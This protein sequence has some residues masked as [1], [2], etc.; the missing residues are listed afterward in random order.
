[1]NSS[2]VFGI[3]FPVWFYSAGEMIRKVWIEYLKNH[4]NH[5]DKP[6]TLGTQF[7]WHVFGMLHYHVLSLFRTIRWHGCFRLLTCNFV[8]NHGVC[9]R[10]TCHAYSIRTWLGFIIHAPMHIND[11]KG[12]L[13]TPVKGICQV[14]DMLSLKVKTIPIPIV[15]QICLSQ[16]MTSQWRH[17]CNHLAQP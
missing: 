7:Y 17:H 6:W 8:A 13:A 2:Y 3:F 15:T 12:V 4:N 9:E 14:I 11:F 16:C 1:M 5:N 10:G